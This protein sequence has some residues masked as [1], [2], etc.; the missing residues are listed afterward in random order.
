MGSISRGVART[1]E[2]LRSAAASGDG[3]SKTRIHIRRMS[4]KSLGLPGGPGEEK[5]GESDARSSVR[6]GFDFFLEPFARSG[7]CEQIATLRQAI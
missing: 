5:E 1:A 6:A 4:S 3:V 2:N 7:S